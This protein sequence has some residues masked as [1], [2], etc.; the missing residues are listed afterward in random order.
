[1]TFQAEAGDE[2]GGLIVPV[3][4]A[5]QQS[6]SAQCAASQASHLGVGAAFVHEDQSAHRLDGQLLMPVRPSFGH[7]GSVAFGGGQSFF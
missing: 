5:R 1:M 4:N 6:L 7:V 3:R 2:R